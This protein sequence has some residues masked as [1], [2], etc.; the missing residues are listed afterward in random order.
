VEHIHTK[1]PHL[2]DERSFTSW[3]PHFHEFADAFERA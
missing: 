2:I 1:F 3:A